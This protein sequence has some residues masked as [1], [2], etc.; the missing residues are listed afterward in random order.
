MTAVL[1]Q[2]RWHLAVLLGNTVKQAV[3]G[4]KCSCKIN[5]GAEEEFEVAK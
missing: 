1:V 2:T 4:L 3:F 5:R